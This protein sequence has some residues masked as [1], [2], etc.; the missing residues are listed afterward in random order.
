MRCEIGR[1]DSLAQVS[2]H[3]IGTFGIRRRKPQN[4]QFMWSR[5]DNVFT[6]AEELSLLDETRQNSI[7]LNISGRVR[8]FHI[9]T[10]NTPT[11]SL[12]AGVIATGV[13]E[14]R[15]VVIKTIGLTRSATSSR[16]RI[17]VPS[18]FHMLLQGKLVGTGSPEAN[19]MIDILN[20][21][22]PALI[23][24]RR[25]LIEGLEKELSSGTAS[26]TLCQ[27]FYET[28]R[29]CARPSFANVAI[30]YLS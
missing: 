29:N 26:Q 11:C 12:V 24:E 14:A 2:F 4:A 16:I 21:N 15:A 8:N 7:T 13:Q 20:L 30:S 28:D 6:V 27:D 19:M 9:W 5:L 3:D 23:A 25:A 10:L 1:M 18:G 22:D 17:V